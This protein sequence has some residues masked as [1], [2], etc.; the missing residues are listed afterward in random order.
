MAVISFICSA[1]PLQLVW[2]SAVPEVLA[3]G[4]KAA[5]MRALAADGGDDRLQQCLTEDMTL[6]CMCAPW[7]EGSTYE[8]TKERTC[9]D[10][11]CLLSGSVGGAAHI[12]N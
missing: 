8:S 6:P 1:P 4:R 7:K 2:Q 10:T 9:R 5:L 11:S 3:L 12:S